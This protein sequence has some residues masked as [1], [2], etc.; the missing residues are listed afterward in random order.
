MAEETEVERKARNKS[1]FQG[2][3][4]LGF[5]FTDLPE[6]NGEVV[7]PLQ[8]AVNFLSAITAPFGAPDTAPS[9]A[10]SAYRGSGADDA[11]EV[12]W[13]RTGRRPTTAAS[14]PGWSR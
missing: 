2:G 14:D 4:K 9:P 3:A 13:S 12:I 8:G 7:N 10:S 6:P 11:K 1:I 5:D